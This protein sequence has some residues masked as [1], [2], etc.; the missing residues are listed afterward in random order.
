MHR[1]KDLSGQQFGTLVAVKFLGCASGSSIWRCQCAK[2]GTLRLVRTQALRSG[3]GIECGSC[4]RRNVLARK[5]K[6]NIVRRPWSTME[7]SQV[8]SLWNKGHAVADLAK[9][10]NRTERAIYRR[11]NEQVKEGNAFPRAVRHSEAQMIGRTF[12]SRTVIARQPSSAKGCVTWAVRCK[13]GEES[14]VDGHLLHCGRQT[15]CRKCAGNVPG[16]HNGPKP[17]VPPKAALSFANIR[18]HDRMIAAR[19]DAE[20]ASFI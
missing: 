19:H 6:T 18:A 5:K 13:C 15:A 7:V 9:Q 4:N 16:K 14:V 11:V 17:K 3:R 12:G 1:F 20:E 2:C 10:F 8:C